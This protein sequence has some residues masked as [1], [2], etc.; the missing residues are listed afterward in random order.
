[1]LN[2]VKKI[3]GSSND[4]EIKRIMPL[5]EEINKL[6]ESIKKLKDD[7]F[8]KRTEILQEKLKDGTEPEKILPEAFALVRE[9]A[10]RT[11]NMRHFDVQLIGGIV[12]YQGK[13]AE[14]AT[15]EGKTLVATLPAYLN[16][17]QYK[18]VH[19]VTVN[20]YLAKRDRFWMG[21]VYEFLG[22]KVGLIQ[23]DMN[24][25]QR[26]EAY[27]SNIVYGTNNEFGFDYLRDNM[28]IHEADIVQEKHDYAIIDEVDSILVDEARTPLII[29][30][31]TEESTKKYFQIDKLV[32]H[33]KEEDDYK[34]NEKER[35]IFLTEK[36]VAKMEKLLSIDNLYSQN[37]MVLQHHIIQALRAHKLYKKDVDYVVKDGEVIIVDEF[38]G[39]LMFGRR[40][41]DGLH[42]AIEAKEN[43]TIAKESQTLA[44]I[45][46]QNF[47]RLYKKIAGMTG[48]AKT[49]EDEFIEIYNLPV[50]VIPTNKE[51]KRHSFS[52]VIYRTEK[53]K[54]NAVISEIK[55]LYKKGRPVL[56]GTVSID[57]SE[58]ISKLL[59]LEKIEHSVLNAKNHEREAEIVAEA[60]QK[61]RV[62]I[63]T[64]MAGR[65]TDIVLGE[66]V[67]GLGGLHV[68]GTERHESRRIDNQLRGRSGRQGDPGSSRFFLSLED[69][70]MRL[71]GSER[72]A[73]IMEKLGVEEGTPIEHSFIT[74]SIEGAQKRVE[75]RNFEI[76]KQLLEFD[77][78]MEYQRK[79][80]Y[81]QRKTVLLRNDVKTIIL[82]MIEDTITNMIHRYTNKD[83]Y[84]EEWD[85]TSLKNNFY[86]TFGIK[87]EFDRDI[88]ELNIDIL[89]NDLL[90]KS[91]EGYNNKEKELTP[92]LMRQIEKMILLKIV[93][94][95]W[96]DHLK[97][98]DDLK[99]GIGLRSY[100][101]KDPL[102]E[103]HFEA[104]NM[105][106]N[107]IENIKEDSVKFLYRVEI[108]NRTDIPE[109]RSKNYTV[110]GNVTGKKESPNNF[111]RKLTGKDNK[112]TKIGRNDPCPCGS[113][114]KYKHC[115]GKNK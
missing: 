58:R 45:T 82:D 26:K 16:A 100:A 65:G 12:L 8:K 62:T 42:Q 91:M 14:M 24:T 32:Y 103:Y 83:T 87:L 38:T 31:P 39:R 51:L 13:I 48:T 108:K 40:Y 74:R 49:E 30:G 102:T 112:K 72:I 97:R 113:G 46:F 105:F 17:L 88:T 20:D 18:S 77:N 70:L 80:I 59:N 93:D 50:V 109:E 101:Q 37:N 55:E 76:R 11:I 7:D 29:S 68:I 71:F 43:V 78:E 27:Q 95:E 6:E 25:R 5:V 86:D 111:N 94:R 115:C 92:T 96:K 9:A 106:Q 84:P 41:S 73:G 75:S 114:K 1:M 56:V 98:L 81:E 35:T 99:Q 60:G 33:L 3:L 22:L 61:G 53:E 19:I 63:S 69:D 21:P 54:F 15:G 23:H 104:H 67:A 85:L 89:Q 36:G 64:N 34:I 44:T 28:S 52:D 79:I 4:R 2:I 10:K 57:K 90:K 47:F 66:G 107:M 110:E